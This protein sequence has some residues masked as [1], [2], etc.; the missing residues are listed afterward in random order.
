MLPGPK[1]KYVSNL[2]PPPQ[3]LNFSAP[4][5]L[6]SD[7]RWRKVILSRFLLGDGS[8]SFALGTRFGGS[9]IPDANET[10]LNELENHI[11][12]EELMRFET[13]EFLKEDA[14]E[15]EA[16]RLA[17]IRKPIG[18]LI[19]WRAD[20]GLTYAQFVGRT[21]GTDPSLSLSSGKP[22][23]VK[24]RPNRTL[25]YPKRGRPSF[26]GPQP[27]SQHPTAD[28][29]SAGEPLNAPSKA[30]ARGR[31]RRV[32][33]MVAAAGIERSVSRDTS[34]DPTP[35]PVSQ[36]K[37]DVDGP[38][39]KRRLLSSISPELNTPIQS[40]NNRMGFLTH[41]KVIIP[42]KPTQKDF[43]N[44]L[45]D[46]SKAHF[47][48]TASSSHCVSSPESLTS[49]RTI[50]VERLIPANPPL[51][52]VTF[53][54]MSEPTEG[55]GTAYPPLATK[56]PQS[57]PQRSA[58][59]PKSLTPHYPTVGRENGLQKSIE[60]GK[61]PEEA[62]KQIHSLGSATIIDNVAAAM[63]RALPIMN[64]SQMTSIIRHPSLD[65]AVPQNSSNGYAEDDSSSSASSIPPYRTIVVDTSLQPTEC[66]ISTLPTGAS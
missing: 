1:P 58:L 22:S 53:T 6:Q 14:E 47:Q 13:T 8:I 38:L 62:W 65:A 34:Q 9:V 56:G 49:G 60:K 17:A 15:I 40:Q 25:R 33:P 52:P 35:E 18:R 44:G 7:R 43:S 63:D 26:N 23:I 36:L 46:R 10:S 54:S 31:P 37:I 51:I 27:L 64:S 21:P 30:K 24:L 28:D 4:L 48:P 55:S 66:T 45:G 16:E 5:Q 50:T 3:L 19:G 12:P 39:R 59:R 57:T 42:S 61:K 32:Y 20:M 2:R 41:P 29:S 11:L